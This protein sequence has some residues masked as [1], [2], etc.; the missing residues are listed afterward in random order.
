[1]PITLSEPT[2]QDFNGPVPADPTTG[3]SAIRIEAVNEGGRDI[4]YEAV[5]PD[6][7]RLAL[8]SLADTIDDGDVDTLGATVQLVD[9][10]RPENA[11]D[12]VLQFG[13]GPTD[14]RFLTVTG[15]DKV[16]KFEVDRS[17]VTPPPPGDT[18][19]ADVIDFRI[20][21]QDFDVDYWEV[22]RDD[23]GAATGLERIGGVEFRD[24]VVR[25]G[26][27]PNVDTPFFEVQVPSGT[28]SALPGGR[29]AIPTQ[30]VQVP[31]TDDP[32]AVNQ[33]TGTQFFDVGVAGT[34][35]AE[36]IV[37]SS[38]DP[39]IPGEL[40]I[41]GDDPQAVGLPDGGL[42]SV[43]DTVN[44]IR[45]A[46]FD[47]DLNPVAETAIG[48]NQIAGDL[49]QAF[50]GQDGE[51][52][53]LTEDPDTGETEVSSVALEGSTI[54][55]PGGDLSGDDSLAFGP[56]DDAVDAGTGN[57]TV[58]GGA[59]NDTLDGGAGPDELR[60]D[61]GND[62]LRGGVGNDTLGGG[63]GNDNFAGGA[64]D[65]AIRAWTGNDLAA[66]GDGDDTIRGDAG[67]DTLFGGT[68]DDEVM[69][70]DGDDQLDGGLGDDAM[71]GGTGADRMT[72]GRGDD[73]LDGGDGNDSLAGEE[74][75]DTLF[76]GDGQ[77][78]VFGGD[79]D[80]VLRGGNGADT[81]NGNDGD[82]DIRGDNGSDLMFGEGGDDRI[83]GGAGNDTINAGL[84]VDTLTGGL[85]ADRFVIG[86]GV[87]PPGVDRATID[88]GPDENT[89][90]DFTLGEDKL[91]TTAT[92]TSITTQDDGSKVIELEDG[93]GT[94]QLFLSAEDSAVR[95]E[96][97][98]GEVTRLEGVSLDDINDVDDLF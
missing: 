98:F 78:T 7:T 13:A 80:D 37:V 83:S 71:F 74:G 61:D 90:T 94:A 60:G 59:G 53:I 52:A 70:G 62:V 23:T 97:A 66:G 40:T 44:A 50:L 1:M 86:S 82:D 8:P 36:E 69:G 87:L 29:L 51:V 34:V 17:E 6:G 16:L 93:D 81:L 2:E 35:V 31:L 22:Q 5:L 15:V 46:Q 56:E 88:R 27:D 12:N 91:S 19:T 39:S 73:L 92:A 20:K 18:A 14:D 25:L 10:L 41:S 64:G 49:V 55:L 9:P 57:D 65:D 26:S 72:A 54:Q 4:T 24:P 42:V 58:T 11:F 89:I 95:I 33:T 85:G 43:V 28:P 63:A 30:T 76:G 68:G 32:T 3:A 96:N 67:N 47:E 79:G 21:F 77:D 45:V 84:G 48:N 38:P 75:D